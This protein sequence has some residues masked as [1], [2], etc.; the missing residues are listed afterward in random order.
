VSRLRIFESASFTCGTENP[1]WSRHKLCHQTHI[2]NTTTTNLP[3]HGQNPFQLC[4]STR[5]NRLSK[6]RKKNNSAARL[7]PS[8]ECFCTV[9][10]V[11]D[12]ERFH[13]YKNYEYFSN[14][15]QIHGF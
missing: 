5:R 2:P 4:P 1:Y 8:L 11:R 15:R 14:L 7:Y 12:L 6:N 13:P 3:E 9:E 10:F